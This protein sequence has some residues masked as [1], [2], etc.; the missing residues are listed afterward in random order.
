MSLANIDIDKLNLLKQM[1]P[2]NYVVLFAFVFLMPVLLVDLLIGVAIGELRAILE[3]SSL[4]QIKLKI[5]FTIRIQ[6]ILLKSRL[7][8]LILFNTYD[9]KKASLLS[10]IK[11]GVKTLRAKIFKNEYIYSQNSKFNVEKLT[12]E[13]EECVKDES[14]ILNKEIK[15]QTT[16]ILRN[17]QLVETGQEKVIELEKKISNL[18]LKMDKLNGIEERLDSIID[19]INDMKVKINSNE[20]K[21]EKNYLNLDLKKK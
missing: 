14:N 18:N 4:I 16:E 5:E 7:R 9:S 13:I 3:E 10:K 21:D 12:S 2:S 11:L 1:P 19:I 6:K 20:K 15:Q 17:N 8:N